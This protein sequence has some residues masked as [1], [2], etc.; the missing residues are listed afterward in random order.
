MRKNAKKYERLDYFYSQA[1]RDI[2]KGNWHKAERLLRQVQKTEENFRDTRALLFHLAQQKALS[3]KPT[4]KYKKSWLIIGASFLGVII[5]LAGILV[6]TSSTTTTFTFPEKTAVYSTPSGYTRTRYIAT[7]GTAT[8]KLCA[9]DL[10]S[11]AFQI[12]Y[13]SLECT[14]GKSVGWVNAQDVDNRLLKILQIFPNIQ[15]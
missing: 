5:L 9:Y 12:S 14:S 2:D 15:K 11:D 4:Y 1:L 8:Y 13:F 6:L 10:S 7:T 3:T